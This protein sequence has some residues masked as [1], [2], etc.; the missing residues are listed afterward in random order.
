MAWSLS[1]TSKMGLVKDSF[2]RIPLLIDI[3][4]TSVDVC[5]LDKV[6]RLVSANMKHMFF[7]LL[8][9]G[10]ESGCKQALQSLRLYLERLHDANLTFNTY[11]TVFMTNYN[12]IK[13]D[14]LMDYLCMKPESTTAAAARNDGSVHVG[15]IVVSL[16]SSSIVE[17]KESENYHGV[18]S[19]FES[20]KELV[21]KRSH[22]VKLGVAD[23]YNRKTLQHLFE[24]NR[25]EIAVAIPGDS[26]LPNL[27]CRNIEYIHSQGCN[28]FLTFDG[29]Y[30]QNLDREHVPTL[31]DILDEYTMAKGNIDTLF[32]KM[33]VQYGP[34]V[35]VGISSLSLEYVKDHFAFMCD[36]FT[37]R[38]AQQAPTVIKRFQVAKSHVEDLI[39]Q[40]EEL[41]C[42]EDENWMRNYLHAVP[43]R[44]LT[45]E[46]AILQEKIELARKFDHN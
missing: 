39:L 36:P 28:I 3:D 2:H 5:D 27:R 16:L 35:C 33:L 7:R 38:T 30:L 23:V 42:K 22:D 32:V 6:E 4:T 31:E 43:P 13:N 26:E 29:E 18:I 14:E 44:K 12:F 21:R 8:G 45:D 34:M 40:S 17:D 46:N 9:D 37:Y 41:E 24:A 25:G 15:C 10:S 11:V 1:F 19:Q 20:V